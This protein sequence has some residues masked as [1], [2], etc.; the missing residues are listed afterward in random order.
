M[1]QNLER[2]KGTNRPDTLWVLESKQVLADRNSTTRSLS[3][4]LVN[5]NA[6]I[7]QAAFV[8]S[9]SRS[10]ALIMIEARRC[11]TRD[12]CD[13]GALKRDCCLQFHR[14]G[15]RAPFDFAQ[16]LLHIKPHA[17]R[18]SRYASFRPALRH[19]QACRGRAAQSSRAAPTAPARPLPLGFHA[20][21]LGQG[22]QHHGP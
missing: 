12:N 14:K 2:N 19:E 16:C 5:I 9:A 4:L 3:S 8:A 11:D 1:R 17:H 21:G 18:L 20:M 15:R 7:D 22:A 10:V 13:T 6:G